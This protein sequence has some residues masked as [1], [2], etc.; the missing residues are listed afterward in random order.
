MASTRQRYSF[1]VTDSTAQEEVARLLQ[2]SV[3]AATYCN[4]P[5]DSSEATLVKLKSFAEW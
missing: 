5:S 2:S 1:I 3:V 4:Q